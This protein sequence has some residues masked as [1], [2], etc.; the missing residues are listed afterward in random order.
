MYQK[1]SSSFNVRQRITI[2][3]EFVVEILRGFYGV[4]F[5]CTD[6]DG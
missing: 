1:P 5:D 4:H 3:T 2:P 6:R